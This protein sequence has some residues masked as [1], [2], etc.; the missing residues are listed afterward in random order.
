MHLFASCR[1]LSGRAWDQPNLS[2][3]L[4]G[5]ILIRTGRFPQKSTFFRP[6]Q[7]LIQLFMVVFRSEYNFMEFFK[8]KKKRLVLKVIQIFKSKSSSEMGHTGLP[9]YYVIFDECFPE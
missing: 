7:G 8:G 1:F 3:G 9:Q 2:R 6:L 5:P 4:F